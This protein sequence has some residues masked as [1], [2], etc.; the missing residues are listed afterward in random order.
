[1]SS[2]L[3]VFD[4]DGTLVRGNSSF[5]FCLYLV[6]KGIMPRRALAYAIWNY[7]CHV[8]GK[9]SLV[10]LHERVFSRLLKGLKVDLLEG[11]VELFIKEVLSQSCYAP[12]VDRLH[13]AQHL[14]HYTL[15]LSNAPSFLVRG[16]ANYFHVDS[17]RSTEYAVDEENRLSKIS[18]VMEGG[19]KARSVILAARE[20]GVGMSCVTAYSDSHLDLP[21][22]QIAGEAVAVN[23]TRE[24]RKVCKRCNWKII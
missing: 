5:K 10:D 8:Y 18:F 12:A 23:P 22:L 11:H 21:L 1:M 20:Q 4:L 13:C 2:K 7:I 9:R 16:V 19:D 3:A 14:G 24:L 6:R 17:W 15:I